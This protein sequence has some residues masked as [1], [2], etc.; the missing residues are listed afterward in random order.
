MGNMS[1]CSAKTLDGLRE[2]AREVRCSL[3]DGHGGSDHEHWDR[4][5]APVTWPRKR[6][7]S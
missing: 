5:P 1:R 7:A 3:P 2:D 4:E 6:A